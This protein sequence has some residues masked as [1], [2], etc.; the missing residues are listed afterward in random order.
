M[1]QDLTSNIKGYINHIEKAN[2]VK[3][4]EM[5]TYEENTNGDIQVT[6]ADSTTLNLNRESVLAAPDSSESVPR[7]QFESDYENYQ[8][9]NNL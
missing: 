3:L 7:A 9:I 1:S 2:E 5:H 8:I 4:P 6:F